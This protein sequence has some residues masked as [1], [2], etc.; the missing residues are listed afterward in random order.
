MV[1]QESCAHPEVT[2]LHLGGGLSSYRRTQRYCSV[3]SLRRNQYPAPRLHYCFFTA[4]PLFLHP[5][6][7]L[8]SNC[9]NLPFLTQGR[10]RR[11]NKAYF[12][13]TRNRGHRKD[14]YPAGPHRVLRCFISIRSHRWR[15][16]S[17]K[18]V[19]LNLRRTN[20]H[21]PDGEESLFKVPCPNRPT[22]IFP[23]L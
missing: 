7:S 1:S 12:L 21:K 6:P 19:G 22:S 18:T 11:L 2:I 9:S 14:L 17:H 23:T 16:Q 13:Q 15:A 5:L 4:P 8:I 3:Y 20:S 10:S